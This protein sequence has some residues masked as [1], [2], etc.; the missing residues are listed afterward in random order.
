MLVCPY[1]FVPIVMTIIPIM[2]W[3]WDFP[4]I[5]NRRVIMQNQISP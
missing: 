5:L 2:R 3:I 4:V 1:F